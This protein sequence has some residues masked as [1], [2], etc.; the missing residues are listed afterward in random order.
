MTARRRS[1]AYRE[2]LQQNGLTSFEVATGAALTNRFGVIS[3]YDN[4]AV[5]DNQLIATIDAVY[6][7]GF[8]VV[9]GK[10]LI[11]AQDLLPLIVMKLTRVRFTNIFV[12]EMDKNTVKETSMLVYPTTIAWSD[13]L[14]LN[15]TALS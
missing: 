1:S 5:H 7:N 4:Y 14:H 3:S 8:L 11:G 9:N 12:H 10:F 6:C 15:V 13:L 2:G